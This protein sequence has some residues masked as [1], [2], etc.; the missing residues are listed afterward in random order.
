[1][2]E[3]VINGIL[4]NLCCLLYEGLVSFNIL[5]KNYIEIF[6]L[7]HRHSYYLDISLHFVFEEGRMNELFYS[8]Y[9]KKAG[10][11]SHA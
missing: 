9:V 1:M 3:S 2:T 8:N 11:T 7:I 6:C 5:S 10:K 4:I